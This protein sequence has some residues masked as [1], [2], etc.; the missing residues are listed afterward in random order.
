MVGDKP[1]GG[2]ARS[3]SLWPVLYARSM[4][5]R[6]KAEM[7]VPGFQLRP[8]QRQTHFP[9]CL[10]HHWPRTLSLWRFWSPSI[11]GFSPTPSSSPTQQLGVLLC[12]SVL[13][14]PPGGSSPIRAWDSELVDLV[15]PRNRDRYKALWLILIITHIREPLVY[16]G[17]CFSKELSG[18]SPCK[19]WLADHHLPL[20]CLPGMKEMAMKRARGVHTLFS[21]GT[22]SGDWRKTLTSYKGMPDKRKPT[23]SPV[24]RWEA[25]GQRSR[26]L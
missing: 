3:L 10:L 7:R 16:I 2:S 15:Q 18:D 22:A 19:Q 11:W 14:L 24:N 20:E 13:T 25:L 26:L 9:V 23:C 5:P 1:E 12:N 17:I 8:L 4:S 6:E 21:K